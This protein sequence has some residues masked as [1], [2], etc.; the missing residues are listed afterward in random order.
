[1]AKASVET[2][3][4]LH[5]L[6][7]QWCIDKLGEKEPIHQMTVEGPVT[8]GWKSAAKS[9]DITAMLALLRDN[10]ISADINLNQ[11]LQDLD[12][13][14]RER[15]KRSAQVHQL[16]TPQQAAGQIHGMKYA[17]E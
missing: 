2:L 5:G 15:P 11:G 8:V 12:K 14:L 16:P 4:D 10:K 17:G 6:V 9:S 1:M 3:G 7:V 13:Q